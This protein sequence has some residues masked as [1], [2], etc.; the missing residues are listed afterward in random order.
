M[1]E[2]CLIHCL[3]GDAESAGNLG[4][5]MIKYLTAPK[6]AHESRGYVL[7]I[8][9]RTDFPPVCGQGYKVNLFKSETIEQPHV[10]IL[11][12][13]SATP[14]LQQS[15]GSA[16]ELIRA[17]LLEIWELRQENDG[18][19]EEILRNYSQRQLKERILNWL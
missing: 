7:P 14:D 13:P 1:P 12:P 9:A 10:L 19:A 16:T 15:A 11:H 17:G 3:N 6:H 5:A 4:C 8:D 2:A 18:L